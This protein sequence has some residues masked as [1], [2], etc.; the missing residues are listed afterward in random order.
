MDRLVE[1]DWR[2]DAAM[3]VAVAV[4]GVAVV[5]LRADA[6]LLGRPIAVEA[7]AQLLGGALLAG[8]HRW[9]IAAYL[10]CVLLSAY[11]PALA[12]CVAA[13]LV[14]RRLRPTWSITGVVLGAQVL[15][16]VAWVVSDI[17]W[18]PSHLVSM[19]ALTLLAWVL[20]RAAQSSADAAAGRQA[21]E[22]ARREQLAETVR[23][24]ERDRLAREVHDVV[25][26]RISLIVLNANR[27]ESRTAQDPVEVAGQIRDTG[28]AALDDMRQV[29]GRLR[30][31]DAST[32]TRLSFAEL[33]EL[34][35]EMRQVGQPIDV[36]LA[37]AST[38]PPDVAERTAVLIVRE[39]LTNA[40]R[41]APGAPTSVDIDDEPHSLRV[42]V[43]N[44]APE[45][46]PDQPL[47]T[48]GHGL[49]GMRE[50]VALLAGT[51]DA[52][53]TP[54]EGFVVEATLPRAQP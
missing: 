45:H 28:R 22:T 23:Q 13:Y 50:R 38:Q 48:G 9:P 7:I 20:G 49:E 21:A 43:T 33:D 4:F 19:V 26:H 46:V 32:L 37:A 11:S 5:V 53:P 29:L 34:V 3:G 14:G 10:G 36:H 39:A 44:T 35:D 16:V 51:W 1:P 52:K 47:T 54:E 31:D 8:L 40:V 17:P 15:V 42:R 30:H 2:T 41:H 6:D 18:E 27:I 25:A 24:G 12:T